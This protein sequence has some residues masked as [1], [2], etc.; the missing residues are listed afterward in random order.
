MGAIFLLSMCMGLLVLRLFF[1]R[2][3]IFFFVVDGRSA[4]IFFFFLVGFVDTACFYR[5]RFKSVLQAA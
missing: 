4:L 3:W 2:C 5:F 1:S